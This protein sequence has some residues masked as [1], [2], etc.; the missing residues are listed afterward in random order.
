MSINR[1]NTQLREKMELDDIELT[2]SEQ[3]I[4][5]EEIQKLMS[6]GVSCSEAIVIVSQKIREEKGQK[7]NEF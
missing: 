3:Q 1:H 6:N 4:A 5:V 7:D 2:H